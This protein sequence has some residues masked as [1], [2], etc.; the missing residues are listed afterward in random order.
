MQVKVLQNAP[1]EQSAIFSTF[2]KLPFVFKTF[3]CLYLSGRLRQILLYYKHQLAKMIGVILHDPVYAKVTIKILSINLV[4]GRV[5]AKENDFSVK[6]S[7]NCKI[8]SC[9]E[10]V[11][12]DHI[13]L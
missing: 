9:H 10:A 13:L 12:S 7:F 8:A 2:I 4:M 1:R 3:F 11:I 6:F 5:Y